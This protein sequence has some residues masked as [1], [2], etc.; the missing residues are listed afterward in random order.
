V[1]LGF[2][3]AK[4]PDPP[5][6]NSAGRKKEPRNVFRY[7]RQ[8]LPGTEKMEI[9]NGRDEF[10]NHNGRCAA[11]LFNTHDMFWVV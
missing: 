7:T 9:F 1:A 6:L 4:K 11:E 2:R 5:E 3:S 10:G 8:E